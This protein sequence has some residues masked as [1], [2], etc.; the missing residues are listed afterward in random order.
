MD[1][2]IKINFLVVN[3]LLHSKQKEL[4]IRI[5]IKQKDKTINFTAILSRYKEEIFL[6]SFHWN[7][8]S[9]SAVLEGKFVGKGY[10]SII[11]G[12]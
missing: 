7:N 5:I 10:I 9:S 6:L 8:S 2:P 12:S 11:K 1:F 3:H 4:I